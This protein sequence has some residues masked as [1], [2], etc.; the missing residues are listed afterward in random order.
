MIKQIQLRGISRT[1]SDRLSEDGGLSES[2]N[3]YMDTAENAPVLIPEDVTEKIGLPADLQ[4]DR[5]FIHKTASYQ[6]VLMYNSSTGIVSA[7]INGEIKSFYNAGQTASLSFASVGNTLLVSTPSGV[8]YFL[9]KDSVYKSLGS[10]IPFP[11]FR[12]TAKHVDGLSLWERKNISF[13]IEE[14]SSAG[15][16]SDYWLEQGEYTEKTWNEKNTLTEED[17]EKNIGTKAVNDICKEL[18]QTVYASANE[19]KVFLD[20]VFIRYAITLYDDSII[21]SVPYLMSGGYEDPLFIRYVK[22]S[23]DWYK[24][25]GESVV[26]ETY[27]ANNYETVTCKARYPYRIQAKL[28]DDLQIFEEWKDLIKSIDFYISEKGEPRFDEIF[29]TTC[30]QQGTGEYAPYYS[31][32]KG[33][34]IVEQ[35]IT[36]YEWLK[37]TKTYLFLS[38]GGPQYQNG[39]FDRLLDKG[40]FFKL[41]SIGYKENGSEGYASFIRRMTELHEGAELKTDDYFD[42]YDALADKDKALYGDDMLHSEIVWS[43][44]YTFNNS[45]IASGV[46]ENVGT[47]STV[48]TGAAVDI[49]SMNALSKEASLESMFSHVNP[50]ILPPENYSVTLPM[51]F[52]FIVQE[53]GRAYAIKGRNEKGETL[54]VD[55]NFSYYGYLVFP[56]RNCKKVIVGL[57]YGYQKEF[58]MKPHPMLDCSYAYIGLE[59]NI[60]AEVSD[61]GEAMDL[62]EENR[63]IDKGNRI[64]VTTIDNPFYYPQ[65]GI[66]TFQ[67]KVLG[68]AVATSALSQGQFGQFPLYVFTEDGIWAME[69]AAD[70]SFVSQKPLSREV[71]INPDSIT[72]ID[73]AVVF[74]TSKGVM[75]V[76]G[77]QVM[78]ISPYMNGQHYVPNESAKNL[79]ARQNGFGQYESAISDETPFTSFMKDAKVA[80]DYNGQRLVFISPDNKDFQYVYKIDTQTWHK[81]AFEGLDLVAPLNSYP[82]CLIQGKEEYI[83]LT[84]YVEEISNPGEQSFDMFVDEMT[85]VTSLTEEELRG[86]Y[87]DGESC[88]IYVGDEQRARINKAMHSLWQHAGVSVQ[89]DDDIAHVS[90]VY[91]FSTVLDT[92]T[93]QPTAK[94]IL[95][96]RPFDLGMPDVFKSVTNIKVRGYYDKSNVRFILQGSDNGKDFYTMNSLRGKSWKMFR[97]FILADLEPTERI[98]WIDVDFEPRY[99]SKLR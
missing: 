62:S 73:N 70:G 36:Y 65:E 54:F 91:D 20:H 17:A 45:L 9:F 71:C 52:T 49:E 16:K 34:P 6:N 48:I 99:N 32:G 77:A 81:V 51:T 74:V 53:D 19:N 78:N 92:S 60:A 82:E 90:R 27:K 46:Y 57:D 5:I 96:T 86:M 29:A 3:M 30:K 40:L 12:F 1:P 50:K 83:K 41:E 44:A 84:L 80:Y 23:Y 10:Q 85:S 4:A 21:S 28:M 69:T 76:Q 58:S 98:S 61:W 72:S 59:R 18:A 7:S 66:K 37:E 35:G 13:S 97:L 63:K 33:N 67:A 15:N 79:I 55:E 11:T 47:G 93:S 88:T 95:I 8:N 31:V 38:V 87:Y 56:H 22:E 64:Y 25:V 75:M 2:L 68:V 94:G 39:F 89:Y 14:G 24:T 26:T 42:N 43:Q